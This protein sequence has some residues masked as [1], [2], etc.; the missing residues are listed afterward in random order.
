ML[1]VEYYIRNKNERIRPAVLFDIKGFP[2]NED[3]LRSINIFPIV[4]EKP[5][6][7]WLTEKLVAGELRFDENKQTYIEPYA[8]VELSDAEKTAMQEIKRKQ[9]KEARRNEILA[10]LDSLDSRSERCVR[11]VSKALAH[12]QTPNPDDL[13]MV[14]GYEA[15]AE[16]LREELRNLAE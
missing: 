12:G 2:R 8:V 4:Q 5:A 6:Y 7:D 13:E 11:A 16:E 15:Q 1:T 14:D 10:E 9:D 3:T